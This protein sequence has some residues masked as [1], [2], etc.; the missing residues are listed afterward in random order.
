M[1]LRRLAGM[2]TAGSLAIGL[3]GVSATPVLA[4]S[5]A[6]HAKAPLLK[7]L[8]YT[9]LSTDGEDGFL[10]AHF[11]ATVELYQKTPSIFFK[12]ESVGSHNIDVEEGPESSYKPGLH[13]VSFTGDAL[14]GGTF[15]ITLIAREGPPVHL[16][17][18]TDPATLAVAAA[19]EGAA[20]AGTVTKI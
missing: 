1:Q 16:N 7:A 3:A 14:P 2:L 6:K 4:A 19:P 12:V 9:P 5:S 15:K 17:K 18:S 13:K 11:T 8:T 10:E 20:G